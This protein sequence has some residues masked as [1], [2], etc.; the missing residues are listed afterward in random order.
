MNILIIDKDVKNI[1][2]LKRTIKVENKKIDVK[3]IDKGVLEFLKKNEVDIIFLDIKF[4]GAYSTSKVEE[5]HIKHPHIEFIY[6]GLISEVTYMQKCMEITGA[7]SLLRPLKTR[8]ILSAVRYATK[9]IINKGERE[10]TEATTQQGIENEYG[11]F[12]EK[13][14]STLIRG[15]ICRESE[16]FEELQFHNLKV[17]KSFRIVNVKI[18]NFKK[19]I[20]T[21]ESQEKFRLLYEIKQLFKGY[22]NS[23]K[24]IYFYKDFTCVTAIVSDC[25][26][27]LDLVNT[28][29]KCNKIIRESLGV[30]TSMGIGRVCHK[31]SD[32]Y[33][34]YNE[35]ESAL[36]Y[37]YYLGEGSVLPIEF[38]EFKTPVYYKFPHEHEQKLIYS[39]GIGN[40][41]YSRDLLGRILEPYKTTD[42][43]AT[44]YQKIALRILISI[45]KFCEEKYMDL[46]ERFNSIFSMQDVLKLNSLDETFEYLDVFLRK[47]T[48]EIQTM[49]D[50]S[51][52]ISVAKAEDYIRSHYFDD[53]K[54]NTLSEEIGVSPE[55]LNKIFMEIKEKSIKDF[56]T[57]VRLEMAKKIMRES[58][59]GDISVA[60]KVGYADEKYFR[61]VF[62]QNEKISTSGYRS[63]YGIYYN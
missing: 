21:M 40:Y 60:K 16:I 39:A 42:Y 33:I 24:N 20:L 1:N 32:I 48:L 4:F 58:R 46:R 41:E 7:S 26:N 3:A 55:F 6:F 50:E 52:R 31:L 23:D 34:S 9:R 56:I 27:L 14:F 53:L 36:I 10:K 51:N 44:V 11:I 13:F 15:M 5:I 63:K 17:G 22:L 57:D 30:S 29:E 61:S 28:L 25:E 45:N 43:G 35:A 62:Q 37:R 47:F 2:N 12:K 49:R 54:L 18:D 38:L 8:E 59:E 19:L